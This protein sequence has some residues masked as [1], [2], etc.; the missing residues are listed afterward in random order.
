MFFV[1]S[2][3]FAVS[4]CVV[5]LN[6]I[7]GATVRIWTDNVGAECCLRAGGARAV[8]HNVVVHAVWLAAAEGRFHPWF[9]RVAS[10][11]NIAD[12]PTRFD[13][14]QSPALNALG[15]QWTPPLDTE[16]LPWLHSLA[17]DGGAFIRAIR[18][19]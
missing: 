16:Q 10:D 5:L 7:S 12:E 17:G 1:G 6:I 4:S 2:C 15:A 11:D 9:V 8:D 3:K 13:H 19:A 18:N 14:G